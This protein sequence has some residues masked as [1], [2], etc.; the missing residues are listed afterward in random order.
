[1]QFNFQDFYTRYGSDT[2]IKSVKNILI[3]TKPYI[4]PLQ[5]FKD[6]KKPKNNPKF[7]TD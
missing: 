1:M 6:K 4:C 2:Y 5:I 3:Q 7:I